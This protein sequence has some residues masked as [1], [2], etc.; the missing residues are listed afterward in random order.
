MKVLILS[1]PRSY[2]KNIQDVIAAT[3]GQPQIKRYDHNMTAQDHLGELLNFNECTWSGV[4]ASNEIASVWR[5]NEDGSPLLIDGVEVQ[6]NEQEL[7]YYRPYVRPDGSFGAERCER[8]SVDAQYVMGI[9]DHIDRT[10]MHCVAKLFPYKWRDMGFTTEEIYALFDRVLEVFDTVIPV[11]R[12]DGEA[13]IRSAI[14]SVHNGWDAREGLKK[15]VRDPQDRISHRSYRTWAAR[16]NYF[17]RLCKLMGLR[18][19]WSEDFLGGNHVNILAKYGINCELPFPE[20]TEYSK[21]QEEIVTDKNDILI[22]G[23]SAIGRAVAEVYTRRGH[24]VQMCGRTL[25]QRFDLYDRET[26]ALLDN[27]RF[28]E[29]HF[30]VYDPTRNVDQA[31]MAIELLARLQRRPGLRVVVYSSEWG[32]IQRVNQRTVANTRYKMTKAALNM[33][34]KCLAH[35]APTR[36]CYLLIHPGEFKSQLNANCATEPAAMAQKIY[37]YLQEWDQSF[38]FVDVVNNTEIPY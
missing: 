20:K 3:L 8:N 4:T 25:T 14:A 29:I 38:R 23:N 30:T 1:V 35:S 18:P 5:A 28:N 17:R 11:M 15:I 27:P 6:P 37:D 33:G 24:Y 26:W 34:V 36:S 19:E 9:L 21:P 12:L 2:T 32:S 31:G 22:V 13:R 16:E 7:K 10:P